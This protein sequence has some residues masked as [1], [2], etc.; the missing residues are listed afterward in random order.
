MNENEF[1]MHVLFC[2]HSFIL[3][4]RA[5]YGIFLWTVRQGG[6]DFGRVGLKDNI[7]MNRIDFRVDPDIICSFIGRITQKGFSGNLF[8]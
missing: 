3:S 1:C 8:L 5:C 4:V 7:V 2:I 6:Y